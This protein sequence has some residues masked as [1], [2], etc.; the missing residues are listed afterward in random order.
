MGV[1]ASESVMVIIGRYIHNVK[2]SKMKMAN[3]CTMLSSSLYKPPD[4]NLVD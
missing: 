3:V 1:S 2:L 4:K